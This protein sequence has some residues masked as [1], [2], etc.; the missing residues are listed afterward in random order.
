[1]ATQRLVGL[2]EPIMIIVMAAVVGFVI[3]SVL[4]PIFNMYSSIG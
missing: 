1:M 2:M 3:V 4:L